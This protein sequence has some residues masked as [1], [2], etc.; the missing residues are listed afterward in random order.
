[1][2]LSFV[3]EDALASE[4]EHAA[5]NCQ[6]SP[7]AFAAEC[8]ESVLASRRLPAVP[9]G[10]NGARVL[11]SAERVQEPLEMPLHCKLIA[12]DMTYADNLI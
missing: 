5:K 2:E 8:V 6:L 7:K 1:M 11:Q 9:A 4:L 3:L 10:R 12:E